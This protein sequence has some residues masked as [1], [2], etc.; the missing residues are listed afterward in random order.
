MAKTDQE[1]AQEVANSRGIQWQYGGDRSKVSAI[2]APFLGERRRIIRPEQDMIIGYQPDGRAIIETIP[3]QYGE[4]EYDPSYAPARR[5]LGFIGDLV[6]GDANEQN[7]AIGQVVSALRGIPEIAKSQYQAGMAGGVSFNPETQTLTEFDPTLVPAGMAP[8]GIQGVMSTGA[9]ELTLG[10]MGSKL[11]R[12]GMSREEGIADAKQLMRE[13]TAVPIQDFKPLEGAP[14]YT[15]PLDMAGVDSP[16]SR[17]A[18]VTA[19]NPP[20]MGLSDAENI[21]RTNELGDYLIDEY[22]P[23]NVSLVKGDY[24]SPERTFMVEN[25][26]PIAAAN[27]GNRYG[28]DSVF[29]DRGILYTSGSGRTGAREQISPLTGQSGQPIYKPNVDSELDSFYTE[30]QPERG[31]PIRFSFPIDFNTELRYPSGDLAPASGRGVHFSRQEGLTETNPEYYGTGSAGAEE[32]F[33]GRG[34]RAFGEGP[35]RTYFY[36]PTG[37]EADVIPEQVVTGRNK[38]QSTLNNLYDIKSDPEGLVPFSKGRTDL[39]RMA[40]S[41][42]Y[43]GILTDELADP[44]SGRSGAAAVFQR[45]PV[46]SMDAPEAMPN[47]ARYR[48]DVVANNPQAARS[49]VAM[50]MSNKIARDFDGAVEQY[51]NIERT[52]G[53]KVINSDYARELSDD[54]KVDKTLAS[55][56]QAPSSEFARALYQKNLAD[57]QGEEGVWV[58]TGGGT[59]SGKSAGLSGAAEDAAD[60]VYD[61][62]LKDFAKSDQM[63]SEAADSGKKVKIVYVD[64]DPDKALPLYFDR[65]NKEG[66]TVPIDVFLQSHRGARD[67][68]R[69]LSDKYADDPRVDIQIWSNQGKQGEQKIID[70][71]QLS[72]FNVENVRPKLLRML[73]EYYEQGKISEAIYNATKSS[74]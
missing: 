74:I 61:G 1:L 12:Q 60:L 47:T 42:G 53:G 49:P 2:T 30:I 5:A 10:A 67:S 48:A 46:T 43:S 34:R 9:G 22:G 15:G 27:I 7:A 54:Y 25:M 32:A 3:A 11:R 14:K 39:E 56:V 50:Q 37:R 58:F 38:Y 64:R 31:D 13:S 28:Q 73:D 16:S 68:I 44:A 6:A 20:N 19:E 36:T 41:R 70:V 51:S 57:T 40:Q 65:A 59:A 55:D 69:K 33:V 29:T 8:A 45:Q 21:R 23:D 71:D 18:M 17:F 52:K 35:L 62:T 72:D 24:G 26:D 66:R 4:T 63:I